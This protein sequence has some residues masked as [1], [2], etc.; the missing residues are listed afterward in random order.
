MQDIHSLIAD[1]KRP[2]LLV[3]AARLGVRDYRRGPVLRRLLLRDSLP[4]PAEAVM[5]LLD[6]ERLHD[7]RRREANPAYS[8]VR[9]LEVLIALMG[10]AQALRA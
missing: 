5:A 10:E 7:A 8:P 6:L 3:A 4:R 9:H 1:R 2:S